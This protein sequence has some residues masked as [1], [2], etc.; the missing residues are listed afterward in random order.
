MLSDL[1]FKIKTFKILTLIK[2]NLHHKTFVIP[3][4][5]KRQRDVKPY[6]ITNDPVS[7]Q[8]LNLC[9]AESLKFLWYD[10]LFL[11]TCHGNTHKWIKNKWLKRETFNICHNE[12]KR[13]LLSP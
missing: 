6:Q 8:G 7:F 3:G 12:T 10:L 11:K 4:C 1:L 9:P 13:K 5:M 2:R